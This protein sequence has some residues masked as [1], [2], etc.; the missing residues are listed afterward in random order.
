MDNNGI[1]LRKP[2]L[3]PSP[4]RRATRRA[5]VVTSPLIRFDVRPGNIAAVWTWL[6]VECVDSPTGITIKVGP[7]L[8]IVPLSVN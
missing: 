8:L 3:R 1:S 5:C 7:S 6:N 2:R 4:E